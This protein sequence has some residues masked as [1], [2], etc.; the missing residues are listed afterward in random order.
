MAWEPIIAEWNGSISKE[1][2]REAI[3][4]ALPIQMQRAGNVS[5]G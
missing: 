3:Q 4:L 2:I 5:D 1:A